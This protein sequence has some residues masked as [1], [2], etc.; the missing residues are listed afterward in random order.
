M[1]RPVLKAPDT[2][3]VPEESYNP[4]KELLH[5]IVN[6][7]GRHHLHELVDDAVS[8]LPIKEFVDPSQAKSVPSETGEGESPDAQVA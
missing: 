5:E 1:P 2:A 3:D 7:I 8:T 4:L 6:T